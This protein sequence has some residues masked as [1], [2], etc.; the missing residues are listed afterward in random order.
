M[1]IRRLRW[2]GYQEMIRISKS[3]SSQK[4][5]LKD[6]FVKCP[7]R[8]RLILFS[9]KRSTKS[10]GS[11][12]NYLNPQLCVSEQTSRSLCNVN[13]PFSLPGGRFLWLNENRFLNEKL[14][15]KKTNKL[16]FKQKSMGIYHHHRRRRFLRWSP[17]L[18]TMMND[19]RRR[20][21][22]KGKWYSNLCTDAA[23]SLCVSVIC[24]RGREGG[25]HDFA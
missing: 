7:G 18:S 15:N 8:P 14:L 1:G 4:V 13:C 22:R 10:N 20:R 9:M 23:I 2:V 3:N 16:L 19:C 24:G 6:L 11:N 17:R 25:G 5:N 21:K 12:L